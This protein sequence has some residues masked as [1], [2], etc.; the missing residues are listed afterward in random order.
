MLLVFYPGFLMGF[1]KKGC[2][3]VFCP[4]ICQSSFLFQKTYMYIHMLGIS[5][6]T[7]THI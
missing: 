3:W 2:G 7:V 6:E 5:L 4:K 1:E